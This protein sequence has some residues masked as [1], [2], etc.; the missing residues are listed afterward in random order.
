MFG[1]RNPDVNPEPNPSD[2]NSHDADLDLDLLPDLPEA[3]P[4]TSSIETNGRASELTKLA[5]ELEALRH[6]RTEPEPS[7]SPS[8]PVAGIAPKAASEPKIASVP[9]PSTPI[10]PAPAVPDVPV[11]APAAPA[12]PAPAASQNK[13][14]SESVIG[15]DDFFDG[16]Y[17]S[18]RGVRIQGNARGS[19]ESRQYIYV[20]N[21]AEVTADLSAE[22]ITIAG[23]FNGKIECRG[24]LEITSTGKVQGDITTASLVV[25]EGGLLDGDLH[26]LKKS[27]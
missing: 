11:P 16:Q 10:A 14:V 15:P 8:L 18:E 26:M 13:V 6:G 9:T 25:H 20:E 23:N 24:R 7:V 22:D 27:A 17:R 21:T 19:I 4:S 5:R 3:K 2:K 12:A 1:R